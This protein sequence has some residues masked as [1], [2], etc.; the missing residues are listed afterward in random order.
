MYF[1]RSRLRCG[2]DGRGLRGRPL[3]LVLCPPYLR[4]AEV[5]ERLSSIDEVRLFFT[6]NGVE[7]RGG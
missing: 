1:A 4:K 5:T 3:V 6:L 2:R 7:G